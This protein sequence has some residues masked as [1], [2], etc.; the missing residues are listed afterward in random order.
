MSLKNSTSIP[1][2]SLSSVCRQS[3]FT[4]YFGWPIHGK[5]EREQ[6][7][8]WMQIKEPR[9]EQ[10][11]DE[12][13]LMNT[14]CKERGPQFVLRNQFRLPLFG[15]RSTGH[16]E[17]DSN[18]KTTTNSNLIRLTYNFRILGLVLALA[19]ITE[20]SSCISTNFWVQ[21][22]KSTVIPTQN[23]N[24]DFKTEY[25]VHRIMNS[26]FNTKS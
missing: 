20:P 14:E 11:N 19:S 16:M 5:K 24:S 22:K 10:L 1:F 15:V 18:L 13:G 21:H 2:F 9:I 26:D 4:Y 17:F 8:K 12:I 3:L 25:E 23:T 7:C 6:T